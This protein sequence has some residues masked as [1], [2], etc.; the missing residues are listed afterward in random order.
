MGDAGLL[1]SAKAVRQYAASCGKREFRSFLSQLPYQ[2]L[3]TM[4]RSASAHKEPWRPWLDQTVRPL[5]C[6]TACVCVCETNR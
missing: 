4:C 1:R 3:C 5:A 2:L 6:D